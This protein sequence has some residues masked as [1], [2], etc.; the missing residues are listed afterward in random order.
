[1][2]GNR[3]YRLYFA[4]IMMLFSIGCKGDNNQGLP[5]A[6]DSTPT[7]DPIEKPS[8]EL[9]IVEDAA[10]VNSDGGVDAGLEESAVLI[11]E[12]DESGLALLA[13]ELK[14]RRQSLAM[15]ER[16]VIRREQLL[17][18]LETA[19]LTKSDELQKV[20]AE[21]SALLN[22]LRDKY[23]DERSKYE[24]ER[25]KRE[26]KR[27]EAQNQLSNERE[28]RIIHLVATIK[29]MRASSGAGLLASMDDLD[30]VAVLR[31]LGPRQAAAIL[32]GMPPDK[33]AKMAESMLGPRTLPSDFTKALPDLKDLKTEG[34][35]DSDA[36]IN[37]TP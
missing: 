20:K 12:D 35:N 32:G 9:D 7:K 14:N 31:Q 15:R 3:K 19:V 16:E 37:R 29:G 1:M 8:E 4:L 23:K 30:S 18:N 24:I 2:M 25:L 36:S 34:E 21:A 22:D 11:P 13:A 6:S 28:K 26:Q 27:N 10:P 17:A 33:A 5:D